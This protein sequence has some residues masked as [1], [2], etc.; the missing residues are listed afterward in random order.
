MGL[1]LTCLDQLEWKKVVCLKGLIVYR[2]SKFF[3]RCIWIGCHDEYRERFE[4]EVDDDDDDNGEDHCHRMLRMWCNVPCCSIHLWGV[5]LWKKGFLS[6]SS[7]VSLSTLCPCPEPVKWKS[8]VATSTHKLSWLV[9]LCVSFF[10]PCACLSVSVCPCVCV[11]SP[12]L[13]RNRCRR[14]KLTLTCT[15]GHTQRECE[16]KS[17]VERGRASRTHTQTQA[18]GDTRSSTDV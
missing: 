17:E 14:L 6:L 9:W 13:R 16:E 10:L 3:E 12:F 4:D 1:T 18:Q 11:L 5:N 7:P 15:Y 8:L 2:R